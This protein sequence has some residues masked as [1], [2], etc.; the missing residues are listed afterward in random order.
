MK[1]IFFSFLIVALSLAFIG[2]SATNKTE[3]SED[4]LD[5]QEKTRR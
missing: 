5:A 3:L 4:G 2:A 1:K